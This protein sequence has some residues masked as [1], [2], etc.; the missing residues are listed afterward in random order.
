M[1]RPAMYSSASR[2]RLHRL[3]SAGLSQSLV[4]AICY[5]LYVTIPTGPAVAARVPLVRSWAASASCN[6]RGSQ[7]PGA[8]RG[9]VYLRCA[10][11]Y[12]KVSWHPVLRD[13]RKE[14]GFPCGQPVRHVWRHATDLNIFNRCLTLCTSPESCHLNQR[15]RRALMS[16]AM[17][18][19]QSGR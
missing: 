2:R 14:P 3:R 9:S 19:A 6:D 13:L 16:A 8:R 5:V 7:G 11:P 17:V 1:N 15:D 10:K 12:C 18:R 4:F